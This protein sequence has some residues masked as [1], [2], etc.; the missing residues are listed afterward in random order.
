VW[1]N[2]GKL[3]K[4]LW[5]KNDTLF[6]QKTDWFPVRNLDSL[7]QKV[8]QKYAEKGYPF[9]ELK[10][11]PMGY[12]DGEAR[13][14]LEPQLFDRRTL[15]GVRVSGYEKL[16]KGYIRHALGLKTGV[17]YNESELY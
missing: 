14:R 8:N 7:I 4:Q 6:N 2:K 5:V 9:I 1:L 17:T 12:K 13:L 15:D 16:S 10:I 11:I 3:Y